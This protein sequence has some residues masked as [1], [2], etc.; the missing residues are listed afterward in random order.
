[1][2]RAATQHTLDVK[3]QLALERYRRAVNYLTAAQIYLMD[4]PLL[5]QPLK[6][7]HIKPRLPGHWGTARHQSDL[8]ASRAER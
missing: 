4:N 7:E 6:P 5:E 2:N 3:D 1:M 8:R